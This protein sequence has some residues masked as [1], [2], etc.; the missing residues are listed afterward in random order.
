MS[1]QSGFLTF[2]RNSMGIPTLVL[3]D[4][5][6]SIV[7]AYNVSVLTVNTVLQ[8][9]GVYD[10]AVYNLA[11]DLLLNYAVDQ[12][13]RDYFA[14]IQKN[15]GL[16]IFV[17]GVSGST[18]DSSTSQSTMNPEFMRALTFGDLQRLKTPYGRTYLDFAQSIGTG[19]GIS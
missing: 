5:S 14:Q 9:A 10:L 4:N 15:M 2:I 1:T 13:G 7:D 11:A 18:S 6:Q 8:V 17:S 12:T 16:N 19:W 3:P